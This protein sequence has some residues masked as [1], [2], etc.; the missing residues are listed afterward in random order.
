MVLHAR[1]GSRQHMEHLI[2][3]TTICLSSDP[4]D[5]I[6]AFLAIA[7]DVQEAWSQGSY[8]LIPDYTIKDP[9]ELLPKVLDL[10]KPE[11]RSDLPI[12][13]FRS[14]GVTKEDL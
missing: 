7:E 13:L 10:C 9:L 11:Y 6:Y 2:R 8:D 1:L 5:R 14:L 3:E 4:R 12:V